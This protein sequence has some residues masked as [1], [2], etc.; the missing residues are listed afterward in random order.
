MPLVDLQV[1][2]VAE[3][4]YQVDVTRLQSIIAEL[5]C[6]QLEVMQKMVSWNT[7]RKGA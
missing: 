4:K 6:K 5:E 1:H 2:R 3:R 7:P